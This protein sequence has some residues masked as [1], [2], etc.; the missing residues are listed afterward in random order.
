[1]SC[2]FTA[3]Q[4]E[5]YSPI[6]VVH[7]IGLKCEQ[8]SHIHAGRHP[9]TLYYCQYPAIISD[10]ILSTHLSISGR[11]SFRLYL[12]FFFFARNHSLL[13]MHIESVDGLKSSCSREAICTV[14]FR[15]VSS[16]HCALCTST[17]FLW[18]ILEFFTSVMGFS[19]QFLD[20][21]RVHAFL[22]G[23]LISDTL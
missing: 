17:P 11:K 4:M 20:T 10:I 9:V 23:K 8:T 19:I 18:I 16:M 6:T 21:L 3:F 7:G 15:F 22:S 12:F 14:Y 13:C 5:K 1:M 2:P